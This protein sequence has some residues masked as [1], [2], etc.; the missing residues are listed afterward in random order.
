MDCFTKIWP[1]IRDII[2]EEHTQVFFTTCALDQK[3]LSLNEMNKKC[4][5]HEKRHVEKTIL[6]AV[7]FSAFSLQLNPVQVK[8]LEKFRLICRYI[9]W[10]LNQHGGV[11]VYYLQLSNI[12]RSDISFPNDFFFFFQKTPRCHTLFAAIF[13][14]YF[15][16]MMIGISGIVPKL[17]LKNEPVQ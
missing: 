7:E 6:P 14:T 15:W 17:P 8:L 12:H 2:S 9:Y 11:Q 13:S 4:E 16:N 1:N 3:Q 10:Q 5:S